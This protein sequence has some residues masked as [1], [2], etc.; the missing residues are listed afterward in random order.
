MRAVREALSVELMLE[1]QCVDRIPSKTGS[2]KTPLVISA[3]RRK[4]P[5]YDGT[6]G[7]IHRGAVASHLPRLRTVVARQPRGLWNAVL[8]CLV[9]RRSLE[10][11]V[12]PGWRGDLFSARLAA[13][14]GRS[15][16]PRR[17][18]RRERRIARVP[19]AVV[20]GSFAERAGRL[21]AGR[22][23]LG[24][25]AVGDLP[26]A[27]PQTGLHV[28]AVCVAL[29]VP[30]LGQ[31]VHSIDSWRLRYASICRLE[32]LGARFARRRRGAVFLVEHCNSA[33]PSL[34][35]RRPRL[36]QVSAS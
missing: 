24:L 13:V 4:R 31:F 30:R 19:V 28:H 21:Y 7:R 26:A 32:R 20:A 8:P 15:P 17:T 35:S 16:S 22:I 18:V 14:A 36:G 10:R 12:E 5:P 25:R 34:S 6:C 3:H 1:V 33:R 29:C 23:R 11:P 2:H 27:V 9:H